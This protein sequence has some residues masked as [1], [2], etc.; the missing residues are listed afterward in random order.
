M[1]DWKRRLLCLNVH[2]VKLR[3]VAQMDH[4]GWTDK[5]FSSWYSCYIC[6]YSPVSRN[7]H[8]VRF[9]FASLQTL[10]S[11]RN[12]IVEAKTVLDLKIKLPHMAFVT[13]NHIFVVGYSDQI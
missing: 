6:T 3:T 2:A 8:V 1:K 13:G 5:K 11:R 12:A 7:A 4:E 9:L 10:R